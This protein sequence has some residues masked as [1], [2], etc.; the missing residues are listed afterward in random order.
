MDYK[1]VGSIFIFNTI[2]GLL[3][4][5]AGYITFTAF[6]N[7]YMFLVE[8]GLLIVVIMASNTPLVKG[9]AMGVL[10]LS[11]F[12]YFFTIEIPYYS[13][14][15]YPLIFIPNFFILGFVMLE[16]GKG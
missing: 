5:N 11:I 10:A 16:A 9:I 7:P 14:I 12:A 8:Q 4:S 1:L 3:L 6:N 15:I 13:E 2:V